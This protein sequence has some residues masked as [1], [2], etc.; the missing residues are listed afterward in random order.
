MNCY[1]LT[2]DTRRAPGDAIDYAYGI[3]DV[4]WSYSAELRD[5]GTVSLPIPF[6]S[7]DDYSSD[8]D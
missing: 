7:Q 1:K 2:I 6:T 3:T 5:T 8:R 4:K